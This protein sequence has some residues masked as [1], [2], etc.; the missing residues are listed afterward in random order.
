MP[1]DPVLTL[2]EDIR[3][4]RPAEL[5]EWY[6]ANVKYGPTYYGDL[7]T[8]GKVDEVGIGDLGW[9]L[10]LA[11][12]P[13]GRAAQSLVADGPVGIGDVPVRSLQKLKKAE[14]RQIV[15]GIM[16]I[17][18]LE[19]F[20]SA[21]ATKILHPK[22]RRSVPVFDNQAICGALLD[23]GWAPGQGHRGATVKNRDRI[24]EALDAVYWAV[25]QEENAPA[26]KAL[27]K[28]Y[29]HRTRIELF[30]ICW[31]SLFGGACVEVDGTWQ[32][33]GTPPAG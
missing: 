19:G 31:G 11:G 16:R 32:V 2:R 23:R 29:P 7:A 17:I 1:E 8:S 5:V 24:A 9:G 3:I 15:D 14:R 18:E 25:S 26:W 10:L 22:R 6:D 20:G 33:P 12:R 13:S 28:A 4:R 21:L 30:D 27:K